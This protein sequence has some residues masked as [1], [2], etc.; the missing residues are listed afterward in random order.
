MRHKALLGLCGPYAEPYAEPYADSF[1]QSALCA[2]LC[3]ENYQAS[4]N[5][6]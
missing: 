6:L 1:V 5:A 4:K 3:I 2:Q